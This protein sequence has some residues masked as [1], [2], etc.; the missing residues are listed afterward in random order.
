MVWSTFAA[1]VSGKR[2][3]WLYEITIDGT[4][5]RITTKRGGYTYGGNTYTEAALR[6]SNIRQTQMIGRAEM[7]LVF[8][9]TNALAQTIRDTLNSIE[10]RVTIRSGDENDPDQ[11]FVTRFDGRIVATRPNLTAIDLVCENRFTAFRRKAIS[12]VM[13][14]PCRYALYFGGCGLDREDYYLDGT[15]TA[16]TGETITVT[17]AAAQADDYYSGG[18][19]RYNGRE[20]MIVR[21]TG[22]TLRMIGPVDGLAT[23]IAS[24]GTAPVEIAPGCNRALSDCDLKFGNSIN[25]GGFHLMTDNPF[26]GRN[27]F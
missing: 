26:D 17:E 22:S 20:Q 5:N 25:Y 11:E 2:P 24:I 27:V 12:A 8:A 3:V 19:L 4:V 13:Q 15:A 10:T 14:R 16:Y 6:H 18:L 9:R 21:H 7:S 1:L 23:E